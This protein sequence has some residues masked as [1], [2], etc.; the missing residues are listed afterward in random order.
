ANGR[1]V[2]TAVTGTII[3][4]LV[5]PKD[6]GGGGGGGGG[7]GIVEFNEISLLFVNSPVDGDDVA[8][9]LPLDIAGD[10]GSV[11]LVTGTDV[12]S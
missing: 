6:T 4:G 5:D 1:A 8:D 12:L 2:A 3:F 9:R 7:G 11:P 10:D